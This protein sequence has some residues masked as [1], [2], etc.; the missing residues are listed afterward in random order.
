MTAQL[1]EHIERLPIQVYRMTDSS[2]VLAEE[3]HRD[4][5]DRYVVISRPLQV[6]R[7]VTSPTDIKT[8]LIPW[9]IGE[10]KHMRVY[11]D[12]V[13]A[14]TSATFDQKYTYS[15]Y[16]LMDSLKGVMTP[17]EIEELINSDGHSPVQPLSKSLPLIPSPPPI[18]KD[19]KLS[20]SIPGGLD[21][22]LHANLAK[23]KR[24]TWN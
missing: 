12:S 7:V 18:T 19:T 15:R 8:V 10:T 24:P 3:N 21:P 11:L 20:A 5:S 4:D 6:C 17:A 2:L 22:D 9:M 14:E 16:F 13:I 1:H 23:Q